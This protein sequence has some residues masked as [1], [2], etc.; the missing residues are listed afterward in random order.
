MTTALDA[1]WSTL[2]LSNFYL[3]FVQSAVRYLAGGAVPDG[4]LSPGKVI[5]L[6]FD[7]VKIG[8]HG[9]G[10]APRWQKRKT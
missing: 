5:Q 8:P 1:D 9:N 4:N 2:P 3:P 6:K 10:D 7:E